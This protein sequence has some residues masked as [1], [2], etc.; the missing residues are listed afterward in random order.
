MVRK[1]WRDYIGGF[2]S[3]RV[4]D[5]KISDSD[6]KDVNNVSKNGSLYRRL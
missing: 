6:G 3:D 1:I 5:D 2:R 4:R